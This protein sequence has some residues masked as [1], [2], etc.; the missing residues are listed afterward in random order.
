AA[1]IQAMA[2]LL[3]D[4]LKA[5]ALGLSS[6]LLDHDGDNRP[7][8]TL[9][10]DDA[11]FEA[12]IDVLAR[13]P[14]TSMQVVLDTFMRMT[15]P[16]SAE[17]IGRLC[18][19]RDV[20]VQ[21]AGVPTLEFQKEIQ[22]PMIARHEQFK[23]EGRDFWTGFSHV[24]ITNTLSVNRSLIFAQSNDYVWHEVVLAETEA[25][26]LALLSDPEWRA[27]A[28]HSWDHEAYPHSPMGTARTLLLLNSDNGT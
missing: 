13:Y 10:A 26:K 6:N 21:W 22:I 7:V 20:R 11:E 17:R 19:G 5:G 9:L 8:P 27:R 4:A 23:R 12:L 2:A 3:D 16:Q 18:E 25:E 28:R 24:P 1:E 14:G 15:G